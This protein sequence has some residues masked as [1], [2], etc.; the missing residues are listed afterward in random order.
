MLCCE[1]KRSLPFEFFS[2]INDIVVFEVE[3][4]IKRSSKSLPRITCSMLINHFISFEDFLDGFFARCLFQPIFIDMNQLLKRM[5][6]R[7]YLNKISMIGKHIDD[8]N[9]RAAY[10]Q[11]SNEI[12]RVSPPSN[13]IYERLRWNISMHSESWCVRV[14]VSVSLFLGKK[15]QSI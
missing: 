8:L 9:L 7:F 10:S 15:T 2:F 6:M 14:C 12:Q 4:H 11:S 1:K 3:F 5:F 13:E